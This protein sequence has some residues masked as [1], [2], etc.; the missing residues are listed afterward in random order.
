MKR[1]SKIFGFGNEWTISL[2]E[3]ATLDQKI[4]PWYQNRL[5][6][7]YT[8]YT[9][10]QCFSDN[11]VNYFMPKEWFYYH[12]FDQPA[13]AHS[14]EYQ[15]QIF[16]VKIKSSNLS[17]LKIL[18]IKTRN[19]KSKSVWIVNWGWGYSY[20]SF[21]CTWKLYYCRSFFIF[22]LWVIIRFPKLKSDDF[23]KLYDFRNFRKIHGR[24]FKF[25]Q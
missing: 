25:P 4:I 17:Q 6:R 12:R 19:T 20:K 13:C 9:K 24:Y 8:S 14:S 2:K 11:M 3:G 1:S 15:H 5:F 23:I 16:Q 18:K 10:I 21:Y 22:I 7:T